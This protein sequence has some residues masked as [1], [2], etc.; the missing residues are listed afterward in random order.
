[1]LG[2]S[3]PTNGEKL[4]DGCSL[5]DMEMFQ[6][7]VLGETEQAVGEWYMVKWRFY[8]VAGLL[9]QEVLPILLPIFQRRAVLQWWYVLNV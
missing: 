8:Y 6:D 2:S 5:S 3:R 1:M 7:E 4:G 9:E